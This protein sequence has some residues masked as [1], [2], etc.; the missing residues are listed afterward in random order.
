M[1]TIKDWGESWDKMLFLEKKKL[2]ICFN[3]KSG[4][5]YLN[6]FEPITLIFFF[7]KLSTISTS[8]LTINIAR[9]LY[10]INQNKISNHIPSQLNINELN[11]NKKSQG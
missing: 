9:A 7:A 6:W 11:E 3:L 5:K 1:F 4:L 8:K 10:K 2:N